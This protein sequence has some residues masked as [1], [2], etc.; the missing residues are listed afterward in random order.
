MTDLIAYF[1]EQQA[2][3]ATSAAKLE[4]LAR[5]A[6]TSEADRAYA[7]HMASFVR[8]QSS[9]WECAALTVER[10]HLWRAP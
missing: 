4:A 6:D 5:A 3:T 1:R 2:T 9:A 10:A 8:G 7:A